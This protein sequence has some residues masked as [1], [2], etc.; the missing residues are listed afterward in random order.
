ML[1]ILVE[2]S[3]IIDSDI[4]VIKALIGLKCSTVRGVGI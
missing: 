1:I 3:Y 2:K 4:K